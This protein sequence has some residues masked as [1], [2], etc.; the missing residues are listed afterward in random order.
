M[1]PGDRLVVDG[2]MKLSLMPPG[3]PVKIDDG[4]GAPADKKGGPADKKG[5]PMGKKAPEGMKA[6]ADK[7][8]AP[9]KKV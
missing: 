6:P 8:A 3:V 9:E 5:G 7:K 1:K 4:T 2:V